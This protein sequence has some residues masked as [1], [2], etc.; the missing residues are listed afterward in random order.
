MLRLEK[1]LIEVMRS[2]EKTLVRLAI[3]GVL[4]LL[5][6][7]LG[8]ERARDPVNFYLAF[9]KKVE[10]T[11]IVDDSPYLQP[12]LVLFCEEGSAPQLKVR[13]NGEEVGTLSSGTLSLTV[14][15]GDRLTVDARG[16][17]NRVRL[18]VVGLGQNITYPR[19]N[20]V[21]PLSRGIFDL[22]RVEAQ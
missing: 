17:Q 20:Q 14:S 18:K 15:P 6:I 11:P 5:F 13:V 22:G 1:R 2:V 7:Q 8:L 9:A 10:S 12:N 3:F 4:A 16:L 19:L 21:W